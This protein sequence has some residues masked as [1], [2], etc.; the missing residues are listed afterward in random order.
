MS[1]RTNTTSVSHPR[2]RPISWT[3]SIPRRPLGSRL[4]HLIRAPT[5]I[6]FLFASASTGLTSNRASERPPSPMV[7]HPTRWTWPKRWSCLSRA[8]SRK[9]RSE[10]HPETGKPIYVK[11]GRF[12]PY[13]QLGENDDEEKRNQGLLR[14]M[15]VEDLTLEM[16]CK[17]LELPRTLG[18]ESRK[19]R[20]RSRLSTDATGPT[21]NVRRRPVRCPAGLSPLDVSLEQAIEL[22]KQPKT[23]G[24]GTPKEPLRVYEDKSPVTEGEVKI[25]DGR[26]GPYVTDGETNASLRKGMDPKT[27]TFE[28]AIDLLA[29]RAA[30]GPSKKKKKKAAKKATKKKAAKKSHQEKSQQK[31]SRQEGHSGQEI[32]IRPP[33]AYPR[34]MDFQ[35]RRCPNERPPEPDGNP[36]DGLPSPSVPK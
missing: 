10:T 36:Y 31:E 35:V 16:A 13:I 28:Q 25:L 7:C 3:R 11:V 6:L 1:R 22:L 17:L 29:E 20:S 19:R 12:G 15:E 2:A 33:P 34:T 9:S 5:A 18:D 23:R 32:L 26:F 24:R 8:R 27:M 30:K 14:G 21:S 4:E